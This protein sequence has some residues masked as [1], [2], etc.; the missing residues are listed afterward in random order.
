MREEYKIVNVGDDRYRIRGMDPM[1]GVYLATK[2]LALLAPLFSSFIRGNSKQIE[3]LGGKEDLQDKVMSSLDKFDF[4]ALDLQGTLGKLSKAESDEIYTQCMRCVDVELKS[5]WVPVL[6]KNGSWAHTIGMG[7]MLKLTY[8]VVV[9]NFSDF[10]GG[11]L[12]T[13][14]E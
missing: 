6:N 7:E 5:G 3:E 14:E 10:F 8:E 1:S 2:L 11:L 9:F 13:S 4:S 12:P